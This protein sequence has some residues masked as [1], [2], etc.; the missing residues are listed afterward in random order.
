LFDARLA[1]RPISWAWARQKAEAAAGSVQLF[2]ASRC[3][4]RDFRRVI[5]AI[6]ART[7]SVRVRGAF[8]AAG[9]SGFPCLSAMAPALGMIGSICVGIDRLPSTGCILIGP[10]WPCFLG[11]AIQRAS[12]LFVRQTEQTRPA[13][14]WGGN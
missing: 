6:A 9:P 1:G 7:A 14:G 5:R 2:W 13:G 4:R 11:M 12:A 10:A 8:A 3:F